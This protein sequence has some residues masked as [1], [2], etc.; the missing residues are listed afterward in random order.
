MK[1][2]NKNPG[3]SLKLNSEQGFQ[4]RKHRLPKWQVVLGPEALAPELLHQ[5]EGFGRYGVANQVSI[6][7]YYYYY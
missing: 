7:Y 4:H 1:F 3:S 6:Y 5:R 2:L